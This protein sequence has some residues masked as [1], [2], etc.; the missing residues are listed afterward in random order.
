MTLFYYLSNSL[1]YSTFHA[2]VIYN[3]Y[4]LDVL[5]LFYVVLIRPISAITL[6]LYSLF[7][8]KPIN[9]YKNGC[10]EARRNSILMLISHL[11]I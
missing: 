11:Q 1:V 5:A 2:I 4:K 8:N 3:K 7:N 10:H 6:S 9:G